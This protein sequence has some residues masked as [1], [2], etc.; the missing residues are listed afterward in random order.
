MNW[1][2]QIA[3]TIA[4]ALGG[5][6][7]GAAVEFLASKLGVPNQGVEAMQQTLAGMNGADLIKLKELDLDFQKHMAD[8]GIALQMAQI[9]TNT[10]EAKSTNWFVAGWRPFVG[11]VCGFGLAYVSV[12]EPVMRFIAKMNGYTGG[13]PV[14]DTNL[15]MQ[16]LLGMLGMGVLRTREKEK[17]VAK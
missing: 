4:T 6:L 13:F 1:L 5:P 17:G 10:E 2:S 16:V 15:T 11:W 3:P 7:A 9:Q 14:I 12:I 8:N